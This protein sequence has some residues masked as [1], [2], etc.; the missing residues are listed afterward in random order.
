DGM[1]P[2]VSAVFSFKDKGVTVAEAGVSAAPTG[3][4][5]RLYAEISNSSTTSI[6]TG[7]ALANPSAT[8]VTV[9][10]DVLGM[11]GSSVLPTATL[12]LPANGQLVR[13][14][15]ELFPNLNA[16]F[17]GFLK[18]TASAP[19]GVTGLRTRY[20]QRNDFLIATTPARDD[21]QLIT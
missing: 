19:I 9:N 18:F 14:V 21:N 13:F 6:Q 20:N 17:H 2:A 10:V 11:D 15:G 8:P 5:F 1:T 4:A 12:R 7:L 16:P 3:T